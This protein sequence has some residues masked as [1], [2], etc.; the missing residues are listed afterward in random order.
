MT[1]DERLDTRTTSSRLIG[2]LF[3]AGFLFYG[4]GFALVSSVI[5][6][7]HFLASV[8][9]HKATL[10]VGAFLMLL[11]TVVD[12]GK[13]VLFFPLLARHSRRAAQTYLAAM[14]VEVVL[15]AAGA[16]LFFLLVPLAEQSTDAGWARGL[17]ELVV[18]G[19][20]A[21][22]QL[23]EMLLGVGAL[24]LT[25]VLVST[26]LVPRG[27]AALGMAGYA[28]LAVGSAAAL[29]G[30]DISLLLS[31]P[32]GLFEVGL[33]IWLIVKGFDQRAYAGSPAVGRAD[34]HEAVP[35]YAL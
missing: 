3:L 10:L 24:A 33:G 6:K 30:A 23:A 15:L 7:P 1:L 32:G 16:L 9:D 11:N 4:V 26:R 8:P 21:A 2:G 29:L 27:L 34:E 31:I 14:I 28:I 5:D 18:D 19:N 12:I 22:Y 35:A 20:S 17:S 25:A 13:G